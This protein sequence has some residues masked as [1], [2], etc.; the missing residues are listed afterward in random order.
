[1]RKRPQDKTESTNRNSRPRCERD[2]ES[3]HG[4]I[5]AFGDLIN[6][7]QWEFIC[8][9]VGQRR[10]AK[11]RLPLPELLMSLVYHFFSGSGYF[12][13]HV[14]QLLGKDYSDS[15]ASERRQACPWEVFA[16]L[17]R[18]ALRPLA[19]KKKHPEAF[20]RQW[21]LIAID[22]LQHSLNN[23][24]AVKQETSKAKSRRGRAAFAKIS[25]AV[26]LELGAHN[27]LA[28][29]IGR[30][31]E[32]EWALSLRLLAQLPARC[33]LLADQL[34]GRA[35][36]VAPLLERCRALKSEFLVRVEKRLKSRKCKRLK[37]GSHLVEVD[38]RD[39]ADSHQIV[40]TLQLREIRVILHRRGFRTQELRLWTSILDWR[41]APA[42]ESAKLYTQRWEQELY[43]RNL[44]Y[45][46]R[47][48]ERLQSQT[49][50]TGAQE[51]AAWIISSAL[52]ARQRVQ[53]AKGELPILKVS[54]IKLV[55]LLRPLWMM[56]NL[57]SDLLSEKQQQ[58]LTDRFLKEAQRCVSPK[59][60][61]RSCPRK[62]RQPVSGWPR[63]RRNYY[64]KDPVE[65][66]IPAG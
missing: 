10:G 50:E 18:L 66:S 30:K 11:A 44:K 20:Y 13:E 52:I 12:S 63:L 31:R 19:E 32:S 60:R 65:F 29:A 36:F 62:V 5:E 33:L 61:S 39:K 4:F 54:F 6:A 27:P 58:Q 43:F 40:R 14:R 9:G 49:M 56:L 51:I 41:Q 8:Q 17:M 25:T 38:L 21:R 16:R 23:S 28:A 7:R 15:A 3:T 47:R 46:L 34:Y 2:S 48:T 59:R 22:G 26:L 35:A 24:P 1:M 57:G 42:M 53:A 45:E 64:W 37:D 55:G